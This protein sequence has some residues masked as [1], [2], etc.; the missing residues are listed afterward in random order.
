MKGIFGCMLLISG[1]L[2][3]EA[4]LK[5]YTG[6]SVDFSHGPLV[7]SDNHRYLMFRDG[8]PFFYLGDTGWELLHRLTLKEAEKYLEN[9]RQKGFTVIQTVVLAELDGLNTPNR[10]R[11]RP[12]ID[13][14][15]LKPNEAYFAFVDSVVTLAGSKGLFIGLLPTWGDKVDRSTWGAGPQIFNPQNALAYGKFL[16]ERYRSFP[17]IIWING[18]DRSGGTNST[19]NGSNFPVWD[20]LGKGIRSADPGH[21]ITFHPWGEKSSSEWFHNC[22]WLDFNM[23]QTG[24]GQRSYSI[25][26]IIREDYKLTPVKPCMDGEARY[27]DHPVNWR[28]DSLGWFNEMHVRQAAYWDLFTGSHGHTYGCHPI[29]QMAS[30]GNELI[31]YARHYW[32]E[33]L[34]L[35]GAWQMLNVRRL[36]ESR[37]MLSRIPF[38]EIVLSPGDDYSRIVATRGDGYV[39]VYSALGN[40][41]EL[42]GNLLPAASYAVWW[43]DPRSGKS[44]RAGTI[45]RKPVHRFTAPSRG[46]GFDWILVLDEKGRG[47]VPPGSVK[48]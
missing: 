23:C 10:N 25:Y 34:D 22:D 24:H 11:E 40:D 47:F 30:P 18:G 14:D 33:V 45:E 6:P 2:Q 42:K 48:E 17:N 13:N 15:P 31:G 21:L 4:Q 36:M 9:R 46:P 35:P 43:F 28:P 38:P 3:V 20:A 26:R 27:E 32:Y 16:G 37:P 39:M 8:T 12:L 5:P 19:G 29:W 7:V 41:I 44:L 1:M